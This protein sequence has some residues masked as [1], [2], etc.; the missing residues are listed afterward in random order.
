M[1]FLI[2]IKQVS[3]D[4]QHHI[5]KKSTRNHQH[6]Q[7]NIILSIFHLM[8]PYVSRFMFMIFSVLI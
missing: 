7:N 3:H 1:F 4:D 6:I 5:T 8:L 2:I